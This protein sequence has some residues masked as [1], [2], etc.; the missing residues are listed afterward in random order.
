[1]AGCLIRGS[2][3]ESEGVV[4]VPRRQVAGVADGLPTKP[5]AHHPGEPV[6]RTGPYR[7]QDLAK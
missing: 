7:P 1:M 4:G 2:R 3:S 5:G 6:Q